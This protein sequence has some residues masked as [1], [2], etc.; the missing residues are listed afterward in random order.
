[1]TQKTQIQRTQK[2]MFQ[3]IVMKTEYC[4]RKGDIFAFATIEPI[5]TNNQEDVL[6]RCS[7]GF[8]CH[9]DFG[10]FE[11]IGGKAGKLA[12]I[13]RGQ[14]PRA[15]GY[16]FIGENISSVILAP[17]YLSFLLGSLGTLRSKHRHLVPL[18]PVLQSLQWQVSVYDV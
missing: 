12:S 17:T 8:S 10:S 4:D 9:F 16:N 6:E 1:M 18:V 15:L 13:G 5:K 2:G 11:T 14:T 7:S 3:K